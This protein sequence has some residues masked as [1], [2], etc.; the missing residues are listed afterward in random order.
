[1]GRE[2]P[3]TGVGMDAYGDW[4]RVLR[5]DSALVLPGP[6]TV[7]N[8]AHNVNLDLFA[9]GGW[10]LF[11][12][13]FAILLIALTSII[14]VI[15]R[16]KEYNWVFVSLTV[17]WI[18]YQVQ[19]LISINQIGL[20][21]WGWL[22]SGAVIAYEISTREPGVDNVVSKSGSKKIKS[23]YQGDNFS[24]QLLASVGL[25][26]GSL[27]AVPPLSADMKWR[28][29]LQSGSVQVVEEALVTS[30]LNPENMNK[31]F[32]AI[33]LFESNQLPDYA[34]KYAKIAVEFNSNSFDA[35]RLLYYISKST[36]A[37]KD[38]ALQNMKRLDPKNPN[39]LDGPKS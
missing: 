20:A 37:D 18:C 13:Y 26:I 28:D 8:T 4:Y 1:M 27:F 30:Y 11:L 24:P 29:A 19:A 33:Q 31:Y 39:V 7:T 22:F 3:L 6:G 15:F 23:G 14:K 34:Y 38:V 5:R 36:Q 35:W 2:F 9:F 10:P 17:G 32:Q 21:I 16:S 12:A 25:V